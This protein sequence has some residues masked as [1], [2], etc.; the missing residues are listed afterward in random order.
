TLFPAQPSFALIRPAALLIGI[1]GVALIAIQF[2]VL[3]Q[4]CPLCLAVDGCAVGIAIIEL[5]WP[6]REEMTAPANWTRFAWFAVA[7]IVLA[8]PAGWTWLKPVPPTPEQVKAH[9]TAADLTVV[10]VTD[11]DCPHCRTAHPI[12]KAFLGERRLRFALVPA[13][14]PRHEN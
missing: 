8:A 13:P 12:L 10:V 6:S 9:W 3:E 5:A 7:V 4:F 14:M 2:F 1:V 11:F